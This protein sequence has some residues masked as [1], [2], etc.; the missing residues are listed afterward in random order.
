MSKRAMTP[1]ELEAQAD[2]L[3]AAADSAMNTLPDEE[4]PLPGK[5]EKT[6]K[7]ASHH[8]AARLLTD[9]EAKKAGILRLDDKQVAALPAAG[10]LMGQESCGNCWRGARKRAGWIPVN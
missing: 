5:N 8:E 7:A 4:I 10:W 9:E 3:L 2:A 6:G 1:D